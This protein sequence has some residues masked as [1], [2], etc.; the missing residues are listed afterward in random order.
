LISCFFGV[1]HSQK[2][3]VTKTKAKKPVIRAVVN[4]KADGVPTIPD[5]DETDEGIWNRFEIKGAGMSV[6]LPA[7]SDRILDDTVGAA[8][9]YQAFTKRASY[10]LVA[11]AVGDLVDPRDANAILEQLMA[12][13][14]DSNL[15]SE[16]RDIKYGDYS[17]KHFVY[18]DGGKR[19]INRVFFINGHIVGLSVIIKLQD[20]D[21]NWTKWID[22]YFESL[23]I[24]RG[25]SPHES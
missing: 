12:T 24:S 18:V 17:G 9:S 6:L 1:A 19:S 7:K 20:Y 11:R 13:T 23:V 2:K 14:L 4:V 10:V 3:K 21:S 5:P 25:T 8:Q 15:V 22:K 16:S